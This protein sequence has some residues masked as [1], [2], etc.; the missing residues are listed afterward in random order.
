MAEHSNSDKKHRDKPLEKLLDDAVDSADGDTVTINSLIENFGDRGFG[1]LLV[2]FGLIAAT[3]PIGGIPTVPTIMG[4]LT[5]LVAVQILFGRKSPWIPNFIG[6]RG[7]DKSKVEKMHDKLFSFAGRIDALIGARLETIAGDN[8]R[9]IVAIMCILLGA[10][11]P[12]LELLP[13]AAILPA[14]AIVM[15]GLALM[16]RDGLLMLLALCAS[17]GAV[18]LLVANVLM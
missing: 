2:L 18:Y 8:M 9:Y 17:G 7:V 10:T 1:P 16:A 11:M 12:A 13:F 5:I 14:S 15:F 6:K 4:V 3:P